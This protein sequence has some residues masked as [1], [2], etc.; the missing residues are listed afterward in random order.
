M[1]RVTHVKPYKEYVISN[2]EFRLLHVY[3]FILT[4]MAEVSSEQRILFSQ[5]P[6]TA[7]WLKCEQI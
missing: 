2:Y 6:K 7:E 5:I 1:L 4:L 3:I